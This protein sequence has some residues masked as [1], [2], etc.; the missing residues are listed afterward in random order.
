MLHKTS[1]IVLH[2]TKFSDKMLLVHIF[3]EEFGRVTYGIAPGSSKKA[4][5]KSAFFQPFS[6]LEL[7]VEHRNNRDIH[8]IKESKISFPLTTIQVDP[9]K[10]PITLFLSE[11]IY[12]T[13][14]DTTQ[15]RS[16]FEFIQQSIQILDLSTKGIANFHLVFL[17]KL[18]RFLGFYPNVEDASANSYFDMLN[19]IF[20]T[21]RPL[22]NYYLQPADA[23]VFYLL[24][25]MTYE[26]MHTFSFFRKER[27]LIIEKVIEY[28]RLHVTDFSTTKS[29]DVLQVLFD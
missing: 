11:F 1:G 25:R 23:H 21:Q 22:H 16:L 28:Y 19:G 7:E 8:R 5:R 9:V 26:N 14:K 3:T 4:G 27:I 17:F 13:L 10:I 2:T 6:L 24:T 18:T 29:L 15:N 20:V 12:R